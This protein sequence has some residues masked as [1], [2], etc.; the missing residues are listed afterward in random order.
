MDICYAT[1]N[2]FCMQTAVSMI[3]VLARSK[4]KQLCFHLL[5]AGVSDCNFQRL[6]DIAENAGAELKRYDVHLQLEKVKR[7]GQKKWGDFPSHATWARLF[8]PELLPVTVERLLYL[9]GDVVANKDLTPLFEMSLNG[10]LVAA[11]EDCVP[12]A[13]KEKIGLPTVIPYVNAGVL[14]FD[15]A[16]WR[17]VYDANWPERYLTAELR[18]PMADQDVINLLF[19]NQCRFLPLRYNYTSWF[20]ALDLPDLRRL[21]QEEQ[22]CS[23]TQQ[24]QVLCQR[25]AVLIHY[26]TCS[27]LVRPWYANAT[28]PAAAIWLK[29]YEK[30]KWKNEP[31]QEEPPN[32]LGGERKDRKLYQLVG[33]R[34]FSMTHTI[35]ND[36]SLL[37]Y[38]IHRGED[39]NDLSY[40]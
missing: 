28:D 14:L 40:R 16:A 27:L 29:Y 17:K 22:L 15:M 4:S 19:Q 23:H 13:H 9:D 37:K 39:K 18:Y 20:R 36:L 34:W 8:L 5:D 32:L 7:T 2:N 35:K 31:L 6:Y 30:S 38:K 3:S 24:E 12:H 25:K 21:M 1:D 10:C 26:N 11:V 33:K